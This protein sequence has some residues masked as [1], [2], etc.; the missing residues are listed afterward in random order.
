MRTIA[1]ILKKSIEITNLIQDWGYNNPRLFKAVVDKEKGNL[2]IL[3]TAEEHN[4]STVDHSSLSRALET[5]LDCSV[6]V[7][8]DNMLGE[9]YRTKITEEA[10]PLAK[11]DSLL[12]YYGETSQFD[13]PDENFQS[14]LDKEVREFIRNELV[15]ERKRKRE[16]HSKTNDSKITFKSTVNT[17]KKPK[18]SPSTSNENPV[19]I[20]NH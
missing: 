17:C 14:N 11:K 10:I 18:P 20:R 8:P 12:E 13:P 9:K 16:E 5:L 15:K 19:V 4:I 2:N 7:T 3:V 6:V 1:E